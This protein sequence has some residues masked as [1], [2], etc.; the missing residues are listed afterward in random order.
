[1]MTIDNGRKSIAQL[2]ASLSLQTHHIDSAHRYFKL[3]VEHRF[4][5]GRK[6]EYVV[7][8]CLYIVCRYEKTSHML[9]DFADA[10]QVSGGRR[11]CF[12]F[13]FAFSFVGVTLGCAHPGPALVSTES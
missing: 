2:A 8:V 5:Q 13:C 11:N 12:A 10:L 6:T 3:A 4:I 7:A 9:L 1:M